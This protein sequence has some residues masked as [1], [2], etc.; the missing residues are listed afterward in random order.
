[1]AIK[2]WIT[3]KSPGGGLT[4]EVVLLN[5]DESNDLD[6]FNYPEK[7]IEVSGTFGAGGTINIRGKN[8]TSATVTDYLALHRADKPQTN[9]TGLT[10]VILAGVV[11]DPRF[12][13]ADV[14]A[15]D[16]T[17]AL[18]ITVIAYTSR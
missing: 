2:N 16:G 1:M 14:S 4:A 7:T 13:K 18:T 6:I 17:T 8:I 3:T 5:G 11:E 10:A 12:V 15:G 9:L